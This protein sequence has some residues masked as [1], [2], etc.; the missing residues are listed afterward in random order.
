ML[1]VE[2]TLPAINATF[3]DKVDSEVRARLSGRMT[4]AALELMAA[5]T[6]WA[7]FGAEGQRDDDDDDIFL[8]F[9]RVFAMVD[10]DGG[11]GAPME[12][13]VARDKPRG[14]IKE[15]VGAS[16]VDRGVAAS[17]PVNTSAERRK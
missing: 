14:K 17:R 8:I 10:E 12:R 16:N 11:E 13:S 1:E 2:W 4:V 5:E 3:D 9:S 6:F 15:R 7:P